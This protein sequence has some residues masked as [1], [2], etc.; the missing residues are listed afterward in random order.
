MMVLPFLS[1]YTTQELKFTMVQAGIVTSFFGFGS[2]VGSWVGGKLT[3]KIGEFKTQFWSL[4]L[5]GF[6]YFILIFIRDFNTFCLGIF[7]A[8]FIADIFRPAMMTA[9]GTYSKPE[10]RARAM[11]LIRLAI[12][13]GF[14]GGMLFGGFIAVRVGYHWLLI[15]EGATCIAAG[16]F[17]F[18]MLPNRD[19]AIKEAKKSLNKI[20]VKSP[21][22]DGVFLMFVFLL[23]LG[24]IAFMQLF[25]TIPLFFK[26]HLFLLEDEIGLIMFVNGF[27]LFAFEMPVVYK[28]ENWSNKLG[29]TALGTLLISFSFLVFNICGWYVSIAVISIILIT[30]GEMISFPFS[31]ALVLDRTNEHNRGDY[32]GLYASTF[33]LSFIIA[34]FIG[35][36][37]AEYYGFTALWYL[38]GG[39]SLVSALGLWGLSERVK[40][41]NQESIEQEEVLEA[42]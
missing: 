29:L 23:L 26:D 40:R 2:L 41:P 3:V 37:V 33:S 32:M 21:Y 15:I 12:N 35:T 25:T 34:P 42:V 17:F 19:A 30:I 1:L 7:I 36:W 38:A 5:S 31:S 4:F 27:L 6:A 20:N 11:S 14:S 18:F 16:I 10:N 8:A 9:V 24:S 13:L 22:K 39:L 28:L